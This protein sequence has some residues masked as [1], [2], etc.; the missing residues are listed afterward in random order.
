MGKGEITNVHLDVSEIN[1]LLP[2]PSKL[3]SFEHRNEST[4]VF[5]FENFTYSNVFP[6]SMLQVDICT[7]VDDQRSVL[8]K[9]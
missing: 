7:H 4:G 5:S 1:A 9:Y 3:M 6:C 2:G 8:H